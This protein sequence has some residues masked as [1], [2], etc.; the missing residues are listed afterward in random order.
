MTSQDTIKTPYYQP[1]I[2]PLCELA[3]AAGRRIMEFYG[4]DD[5][6]AVLKPDRSPVTDADIAAHRIIVNT[7]R[8]WTPD[9]P[10]VSEESETQ[11]DVAGARCFWLVDPLDGTKSF[12]RRSGEFTVNIA[13]IE[14]D[15]PVLGIIY[16]PVDGMLYYG[17]T[18]YGAYRQKPGDAPRRIRARVQPEG[19]AT[20]IVSQSHNTSATDAFL[21]GLAVRETLRASSSLKFCR[22]AEGAADVYPRHG[23]T[24]E[25]DTAAGQAIVTA[26]GGRVET[27]DGE[28]FRYG[29]PGFGNGGF[30]VKGKQPDEDAE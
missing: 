2:D 22:V 28:P 19:G 26:A 13:L 23:P 14:G 18:A 3:I 29:K 27:V 9:T 7:L 12:I 25:W 17:S 10:V 24:M 21:A 16:L 6:N 20:V 30:I 15:M 1:L 4:R 5:A 8:E 11:P